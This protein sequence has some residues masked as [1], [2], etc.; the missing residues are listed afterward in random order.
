MRKILTLSIS[1]LMIVTTIGYHLPLKVNAEETSPP[2]EVFENS[3]PAE[4][5]PTPES[6]QES[7]VV[8][9]ITME[10]TEDNLSMPENPVDLENTV[11]SENQDDLNGTPSTM[12]LMAPTPL[13]ATPN[14]ESDFT[15]NAATQ[16]IT[17][18]TG[19]GGITSLIIPE[20]IGGIT[21]KFIGANSF[22]TYSVRS[23]NTIVLP[24]TIEE[25]GNDAFSG[26]IAGGVSKVT[27]SL[28]EGLKKIGARA[29]S[30]STIGSINLPESLTY[31]GATALYGV[32]GDLG[33]IN[34]PNIEYIGDNAFYNCQYDA[35]IIGDKLTYIGADAFASGRTKA[36]SYAIIYSSNFANG[37]YTFN[38]NPKI[39]L[40]L[41]NVSRTS[42]ISFGN[43]NAVLYSEDLQYF[44]LQNTTKVAGE[45]A[46]NINYY[47][48][49]V[50]PDILTSVTLP[51]GT[52]VPVNGQRYPV[53]GNSSY[54]ATYNGD[55]I[56]K[57]IDPIGVEYTYTVNIDDIGI[58]VV[59]ANNASIYTSQTPTLT[60]ADILTL[61]NANARDELGAVVS[62]ISISDS[63]LAK[64]RALSTHGQSTTITVTATHDIAPGHQATKTV[65]I[66]ALGVFNVIFDPQN[67]ASTT[68]KPVNYNDSTTPL[69]PE[70]TNTG[71]D[72]D[73]WVTTPTGNTAFDFATPITADTT[74]YAKWNPRNDTHYTIEHWYEDIN[75]TYVRNDAETEDLIGT[76]DA[77]VNATA[78]TVTGFTTKTALSTLS[79]SIKGDGSLVLK[80]YYERESYKVE[81]FDD[82]GTTSLQNQT[83]KYEAPI[84][85]PS[86]P[87]RVN[88][89]FTGWT[90]AIEATV[91]A[92]NLTYTATYI[93]NP[94]KIILTADGFVIE[95][96]EAAG[97]SESNI[98]TKSAMNAAM[99]ISGNTVLDV[100]VNPTMLD[101][102][103]AVGTGG[104]IYPL[105]LTAK[106]SQDGNLFETSVTIQIV[107]KGT[108]IVVTDP[109][110]TGE[111]IALQAKG[112]LLENNE[113]VLFDEATARLKGN[114]KA[115]LVKSGQEVTTI[116]M[117]NDQLTKIQETGNI[118]GLYPL[119][120]TA[121]E[122][123]YTVS[124]TVQV[125]VKGT[126]VEITPPD[127]NGESLVLFAKGIELENSEAITFSDAQA[128]SKG[129]IHAALL[130]DGKEVTGITFDAAQMA[131]IRNSGEAG[132]IYNLDV[133]ASDSGFMVTKTITVV[134][135][136]LTIS[137]TDPDGE[138]EAILLSGY[139]FTI[140]NNQAALLSVTDILTLSQA[141][142]MMLQSN[143][144]PMIT[145]N[146]ADLM[147][148]Q[149][150]GINGGIVDVTLTARQ[151]TYTVDHVITVVIKGTE[152]TVTIPDSEGESI[153]LSVKNIVIENSDAKLFNT[154]DALTLSKARS[155]LVKSGKSVTSIS[156]S[157]IEMAQIQSA[158]IE[159]GIY[160]LTFTASESLNGI[161]YTTIK[162]IKVIVKGTN[163]GV[164][165]T[166]SFGENLVIQ[167]HGFTIENNQAAT[168]SESDILTT[169]E[170]QSFL[171]QA[172]RQ[173]DML[174]ID[175]TQLTII[176]NADRAGGLYTIDLIGQA[177]ENSKDY[178]VRLPISIVVK[179]TSTDATTPDDLN[180]SL[181]IT[182]NG[183]S[184]ENNE[185]KVLNETDAINFGQAKAKFVKSGMDV[186]NITVKADDLNAINNAGIA[187]GFYT[188]D[189]TATATQN[190]RDYIVST[191]VNVVVKGTDITV[192][193]PDAVNESIALSARGVLLENSQ[194]VGFDEMTALMKTEAKAMLVRTGIVV[195]NITF[196]ADD[197][198]AIQGASEMGGIYPLNIT[199]TEGAYTIMKTVQV[200]VKGTSVNITDPDSDD[201]SIAIFANN[202]ILENSESKMLDEATALLKTNAQAAML[203]SG[204]VVNNLAVD[205]NQLATIQNSG[206]TGGIYPL[207]I[208]ATHSEYG[209]DYTITKEVRVIVKG[210][211]TVI[212]PPDSLNESIVLY[213]QGFTLENNEATSLTEIQVLTNAKARSLMNRSGVEVSTITMD[214]TQ[215]TAIQDSSVSG[216][217]YPLTLTSTHT[218]DGVHY[219]TSITIQVV[220]KGAKI[221]VTDPD[222]HEE[223]LAIVATSFTLEN[224]E[225]GAL[226]NNLAKTYA[227][228]QAVLVKSGISIIDISADTNQLTAINAA[229]IGGGIFDLTFTATQNENGKTYTGSKTIKVI[230]KGL[231]V[232]ETIP[233]MNEESLAL[234]AT[235]FIIENNE[236]KTLDETKVLTLSQAKAV[237]V[238]SG[239]EVNPLQ[240]ANAELKAI[241]D[242][243]IGGGTY[244]L[245]ITA[246]TT[247]NGIEHHVSRIITVVVKGVDIEVTNPDVSDE[248]IV[249]RAKSV[250]LEN[251][252][253]AMFD[254]NIA[255]LKSEASAFLV[256]AGI[257]V[258]T[259]TVD[260][261]Q[262][263]NIQET[264]EK[265]GFYTLDITAIEGGYTVTKTIQVIVKGTS[266]N[267][268]TLDSD[269]E[270]IA[271]L[272]Q[273]IVLENNEAMLF[274]EAAALL[275]SQAASVM[276]RSG[277][278][279]SSLTVN[280]E[281][282]SKIQATNDRGGI[283]PLTITATQNENGKTYIVSKTISVAV[284]GIDVVITAPDTLDEQL[285]LIVKNIVIDNDKA[286][287][288]D[289]SQA[290]VLA[291]ARAVL[292][293]SGLEVTTINVD[294]NELDAIT[295]SGIG[296]G[297]YPL[298]YRAT[299]IQDGETYTNTKTID[300]IIK[301]S[302]LNATDLDEFGES[303]ILQAHGIL[304]ENNEAF[305]L[306]K[307]QYLL[308]T[309]AQAKLEKS[310]TV[311]TNLKISE[312]Q[313]LE[314]QT[315]DEKG[316]IYPL[317]I[318]AT[319]EENG[320]TYE[321][322]LTVQVIVK[323]TL[324]E[325]N[326][327]LAIIAHDF[328]LLYEEA[329]RLD[330]ETS[331]KKAEAIAIWVETGE[332]LE[333][334]DINE[335]EKIAI[336]QTG[337]S[338]GEFPLTFK[339]IQPARAVGDEI[340]VTIL[341][342][343][344]GKEV[345][346]KKPTETTGR[347]CQDDGYPGGWN[348][349]E[350]AQACL[351]SNQTL[352]GQ[353]L[354]D[355]Q[356]SSLEEKI[357]VVKEN[358]TSAV[359]N[360]QITK[361]DKEKNNFKVAIDS[362]RT[363]HW[364]IINVLLTL[365]SILLG[366]NGFIIYR[367]KEEK[368]KTFA[369]EIACL[370]AGVA[371]AESLLIL[372]LT[373]KFT[374]SMVIFDSWTIWTAV[375]FVIITLTYKIVTKTEK[376]K[377]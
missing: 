298:T 95:N 290:L 186:T 63:D 171:M 362:L 364:A 224:N 126:A 284:R 280:M 35:L 260:S 288:I 316:G 240:I 111:R 97:L 211:G 194:A 200:I 329:Q 209:K 361:A 232:E 25:I 34:L 293:K 256:R 113:A 8:P 344:L 60:K 175:V 352:P 287:T 338:G 323:G 266:I 325:G 238:Q 206:S 42:T 169:S 267:M 145:V 89:L 178:E 101:A 161:T 351:L 225:A 84:V 327:Q 6:T 69:S 141:K 313:I 16:T 54:K 117:P 318:T 93:E 164:T 307:T 85:P 156:A 49:A 74:I 112:I 47:Y 173:A 144:V 233:D 208:T 274:D 308:K 143:Q 296:G 273:G 241:Q 57:G 226:T 294:T 278:I 285:A 239:T 235:S 336:T 75:G 257:N 146:G 299:I 322:S 168:L 217:I 343:V 215:L 311:I 231:D 36:G 81:F 160:P 317:T 270:S 237:L 76:T 107:V 199:A 133:T 262:L 346:I 38:A 155:V 246:T 183:F 320:K 334:I 191:Q 43:T 251:N 94:E 357:V 139:G 104:G 125:A 41:P 221:D 132:G 212:T 360:L 261:T 305:T 87:V 197:L 127:T 20:T 17:G 276:V 62:N 213:A 162:S 165:D 207:T 303:I 332:A 92:N 73:G 135:K 367:R 372:L 91:P 134:V 122:G 15:F 275:K 72:F 177:H 188:L 277:T 170:A 65:T 218:Q 196:N 271:L 333:I 5:T 358:K 259:I 205:I 128:I 119:T 52:T 330:D 229:S 118:G 315:V 304:I 339:V 371:S 181:A 79:G 106:N 167:G 234:V 354:N 342:T 120:F 32:S 250:V 158:G 355:K 174:G 314:I 108:D 268:T 283:Y 70:P 114:V 102:I 286:K 142:A 138:E 365:G 222:L 21:V 210:T 335:D 375:L 219:E 154:A 228:V 340:S 348:W 369:K 78:K 310:G 350:E 359:G 23:V 68:I 4:V 30:Q 27:V 37:F 255:L 264:K 242:S 103:H 64:V 33:T 90:P 374:G 66:S 279:V 247:I 149:N 53:S 328:I 116:T 1:L 253:A 50:S 202:F 236:S 245:T 306:D 109:D 105:I 61:I 151:G 321:V 301:G 337:E 363:S 129:D 254:E 244:P 19:P 10:P 345:P 31:I 51:N 14:P 223:Q 353:F 195:T 326:D 187:G 214:S 190:S 110:T 258:P 297:I 28:N 291:E 204:T 83:L 220:V 18:Y 22:T 7:T 272:A 153:A 11:P 55:F 9:E 282:L 265:G 46:T 150:T 148:I 124:K 376:N 131:R 100:T 115:R 368:E 26:V 198:L 58:P 263:I 252:E 172:G 130:R 123:G 176:Q 59:N 319:Q 370:V 373:Q 136:G 302:T 48:S 166:D 184:L 295:T 331:V 99:L 300:I 2:V 216:G 248:S 324:I 163:V 249:L 377:S 243:S 192:T 56:F 180:E 189:Y 159:G 349:S 227:H 179:G 312:D 356:D 347:T 366:I 98:F 152:T 289:N 44:K 39:T 24:N 193:N 86:D 137:T 309:Q 185:A 77:T 230:V 203:R 140:E 88:L 292:V 182:A 13:A 147:K 71:Y 29:F 40:Y 121:S 67:G 45:Y 341:V 269:D 3:P 157:S 96:S 80:V 201:E 281:E 12:S 82:D